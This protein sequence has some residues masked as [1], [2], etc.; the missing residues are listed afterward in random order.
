M[1]ADV[2]KAGEAE[3]WKKKTR[4]RRGEQDY[5]IRR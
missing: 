2:K 3:D 5:L 4:V 1:W